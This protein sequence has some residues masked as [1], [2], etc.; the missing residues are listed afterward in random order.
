MQHETNS[1][2]RGAAACLASAGLGTAATVVALAAAACLVACDDV[3]PRQPS[4]ARSTEA[5][6]GPDGPPRDPT[7]DPSPGDPGWKSSSA[8]GKARDSAVQLKEKIAQ[9][10]EEVSKQADEVFKK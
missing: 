10:E 6:P 5:P 4:A 8:L 1:G 7:K 9:H 2:R 3:K